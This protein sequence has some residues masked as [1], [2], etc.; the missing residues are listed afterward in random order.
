[1]IINFFFLNPVAAKKYDKYDTL[2]AK[3]VKTYIAITNKAIF[4]D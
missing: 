1:M 4:A 3:S 2:A